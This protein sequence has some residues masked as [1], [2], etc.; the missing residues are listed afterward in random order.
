MQNLRQI[1]AVERSAEWDCVSPH[2]EEVNDIIDVQQ[3][4]RDILAN[5]I[6]G[7]AGWPWIG[8]LN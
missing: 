7:I 4:H 1:E 3:F 2:V 6:C 5:H 8:N